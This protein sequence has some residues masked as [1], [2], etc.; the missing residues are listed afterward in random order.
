MTAVPLRLQV[1][2]F[3]KDDIS[4]KTINR[5]KKYIKDPKF[6][7]AVITKASQPAGALCT[8]C[9]AMNT[10]SDVKKNVEPMR[11]A[12]KKALKTLAVK[13]KSLAAAQAKLKEVMDKLAALKAQY[14]GSV[15]EKNAL[16]DEAV[17]LKEKLERADQVGG[18]GE[19]RMFECA[20]CVRPFP[21]PASWVSRPP[22]VLPRVLPS[23]NTTFR[24]SL[25]PL[26][27]LL[28]NQQLVTGLGGERIRWEKS[29]GGFTEDE[30][31]AI[32]DSLMASAYRSY[33]G[34]FD[35]AY[36]SQLTDTW[37]GA[38][39]GRK[40]PFTAGFNFSD[41]M[42]KPTDVR[43][44]Q[45][46]GLP[47]DTFSTENAVIVTRCERWPLMVD[48]QEQA[49]RWLLQFEEADKGRLKVVDL[50]S[51]DFLRELENAIQF[52]FAYLLQVS[53]LCD[54]YSHISAAQ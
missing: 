16:R 7:P 32:G 2:D 14:D 19:W 30:T 29:I 22:T 31:N 11:A 48:P 53:E 12:L 33:A 37:M 21:W 3:K 13:E 47:S 28:I 38:V 6:D 1:L 4:G 24:R 20:R 54:V 49:K 35:V 51:K 10:Y 9:H 25:W 52:G 18:F 46:Q 8:W 50:K 5:L 41:F 23:A 15:N 27:R 34:P 42:A 36:R 44:W 40:I 45:I 17:M 39:Q 26:P 43:Q